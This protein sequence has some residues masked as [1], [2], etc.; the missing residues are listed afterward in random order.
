MLLTGPVFT[1][2]TFFYKRVFPFY[3]SCIGLTFLPTYCG[4]LLQSLW[5]YRPTYSNQFSVTLHWD[6]AD[7]SFAPLVD[8]ICAASSCCMII[9]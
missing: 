9:S 6:S 5:P 3:K 4:H 8:V 7:M 1:R 2:N